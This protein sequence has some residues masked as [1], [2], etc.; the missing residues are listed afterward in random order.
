MSSGIADD[1][2]GGQF[3]GPL[4][5]RPRD[6]DLPRRLRVRERWKGLRKGCGWR[7]DERFDRQARPRRW[8]GG[9]LRIGES[10]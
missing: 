6:R 8:P 7:L 10:A 3:E 5:S 9:S 2:H 1:L 4:R